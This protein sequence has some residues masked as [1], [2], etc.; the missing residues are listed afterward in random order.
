[1][2]NSNIINSRQ[3]EDEYLKIQYAA[4]KYF[5]IAENINYLSWLV[6]LLSA[7]MVLVPDGVAKWITIGV[8]LL[9]DFLALIL[10]FLFNNKLKNATELRNYFDSQVLMINESNYT[11]IDKQNLKEL[12]LDIYQKNRAEADISIRN[13]GRDNPPGVRNWYEFKR[14][15]LDINAQYECQKQNIWWNKKMVENRLIC[16]PLIFILL[17][18]IFGLIFAF[19]KTDVWTIIVCSAGIV[20]KI[21]ERIVEHYKYHV[22]SI[23]IETIRDHIENHLTA[24]DIEKLQLLINE[25]RSIPVLELNLIH[26]K[27]AN[28]Y[29]NSYDETT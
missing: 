23:K 18:I 27:K 19:L 24:D 4:R 26:K 7:L 5:N 21:V 29:S 28:K 6:C 25:R 3:N 8:P 9:L 16:F 17:L 20:S 10:T 13:T 11:D 22:I 1:M 15:V 12:A 2:I 14:E